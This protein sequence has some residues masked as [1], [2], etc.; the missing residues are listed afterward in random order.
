MNLKQTLTEK[1]AINIHP[2]IPDFKPK[3]SNKGTVGTS[4]FLQ[5]LQIKEGARLTINSS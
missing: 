3:I 5:T 2:T 4:A 1:E